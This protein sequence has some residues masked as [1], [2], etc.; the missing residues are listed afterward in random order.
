MGSI[1]EAEKQKYGPR[2]GAQGQIPS[3]GSPTNSP[4]HSLYLVL[5]PML[6]GKKLSHFFT[7]FSFRTRKV[8]KS[9]WFYFFS[10]F[11]KL[12]KSTPVLYFYSS[13]VTS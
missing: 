6:Y 5:T 9:G 7:F 12:E 11:K 8:E 4:S 3:L 13:Q 1:N 10:S 2:P